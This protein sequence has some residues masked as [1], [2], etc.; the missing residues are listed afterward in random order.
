[1]NALENKLTKMI[2]A[3]NNELQ[4]KKDELLRTQANCKRLEREYGN[5][6]ERVQDEVELLIELQVEY[7]EAKKKLDLL[8]SI[9]SP[10]VRTPG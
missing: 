3:A 6:D 9:L 5:N 8:L 4:R 7:Q 2:E 1:M 10:D